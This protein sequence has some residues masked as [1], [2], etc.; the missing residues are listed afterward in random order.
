MMKDPI[1]FLLTPPKTAKAYMTLFRQ[2][3]TVASGAMDY[4]ENAEPMSDETWDRVAH[5]IETIAG[6]RGDSRIFDTTR[7][8]ELLG[9]PE[10]QDEMY[11][12]ERQLWQRFNELRK[13]RSLSGAQRPQD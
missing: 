4:L 7:P 12:R 2:L 6:L 1:V 10:Y 11:A 3:A 9:H 13:A 8:R 5:S